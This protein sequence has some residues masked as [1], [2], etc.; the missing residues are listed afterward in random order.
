MSLIL[1]FRVL[2]VSGTLNMKYITANQPFLGVLIVAIV[3]FCSSCNKKIKI[4]D[5]EGSEYHIILPTKAKMSELKAASL[6]QRHVLSSSGVKLPIMRDREPPAEYEICI[7]RTNRIDDYEKSGKDLE[8]D[9]YRILAANEKLF[10]YGGS[11]NGTLYGVTSFLED[12]LGARMYSSEVQHTPKKRR[13]DIPF[14]LD[15]VYNPPVKFRTTHYRDTWNPAFSDWHKLDHEKDG[16]HPDWG[17]W[18]HSFNTLVPPAEYY[19]EHPEYYAEV[20][21]VR[22]PTQLCLTNEEVFE[23][24]LKN[25]RKAMEDQPGPSYWSVSQN[26]NVSYCQC[27][28]CRKIDEAEGTPMGSL[29]KFI[30]RLADQFPDK[31]ISTL[32]YQYSRK[33]PKSIKPA[34]NVNIM[35][36]TIELNRSKPIPDDPTSESF[37][38][39]LE[40]WAML[41]DDILLWDYV[42]QFANLLSPFPNLRVLQPN[43][44]YFVENN[45]DKHFQQG[46]REV[47]GEFAE[48][49]AYLISKLLWDPY[50]D[51]DMVLDDFLNGYYGKGGKY[52]RMY[53]DDIHDELSKSGQ[54][55]NIFGHPIDGSQTW[56]SPGKMK[57]YEKYFDRAERA[58]K[59]SPEILERVRIARMPLEFAAIE[60]ALRLGTSEG[61]MYTR[62]DSGKWMVRREIPEKAAELVARANKQGVT[63]FMEWHTSPTEYL[64]SLE[65]TWEIDMEDHLAYDIVPSLELP[66]SMKYSRGNK[67]ILTD[68]LRGPRLSY[69]YNWL[70]FEGNECIAWVDLGEIR[71]LRSFSSSWLQDTRSW[72]FYP[73][74]VSYYASDD[75]LNWRLLARI[76]NSED[77]QAAG[78]NVQDYTLSLESPIRSQYI[79]LETNSYLKCPEWHPGSGS[80]AWIFVDEIIVK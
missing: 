55:L 5:K 76:V 16:G 17:F 41:T 6:V 80:P 45:A 36:C 29:L 9:G 69:A 7:G 2:I 12:Y 51:V 48:L 28:E 10:I 15:T 56:L 42:I 44:Q 11:V 71:E 74:T 72:V 70:G 53:I 26:D 65:R 67:K 62:D 22:V 8:E 37:R 34:E 61:G 57:D 75:G 30:N 20:N 64:Q 43:L 19:E 39:D 66:A 4:V 54:G 77:Q 14:F 33:A 3:V 25:L 79:K 21:G 35:L 47:G 63:R 50:L 32:A 18:C 78:V 24:T 38:Q 40:D 13:I 23:I 27:E 60:I 58:V 46:N 49:R 59:N 68:G 31:V 1:Y 52:I 73:D